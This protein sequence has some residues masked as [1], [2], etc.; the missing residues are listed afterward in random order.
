MKAD[1]IKKQYG[2]KLLAYE[3]AQGEFDL[4]KRELAR[5]IFQKRGYKNAL[6]VVITGISD[7]NNLYCGISFKD[8]E[9]F[10]GAIP[11]SELED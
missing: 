1:E 2:E 3:K 10:S 4:I 7:D 5:K 9:D 8:Q 11:L 6:H